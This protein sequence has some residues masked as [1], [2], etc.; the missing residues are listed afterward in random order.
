[1]PE[2]MSFSNRRFDSSKPALVLNPKVSL[3]SA[4][5]AGLKES[6]DVSL[7][8]ILFQTALAPHITQPRVTCLSYIFFQK[9]VLVPPNNMLWQNEWKSL[10]RGHGT[11]VLVGESAARKP[12][13]R[14]ARS[15]C[16][17]SLGGFP[18]TLG[19]TST[20]TNMAP[21]HG[22]PPWKRRFPFWGSQ[23]FSGFHVSF[24][25]GDEF[26]WSAGMKD[27]MVGLRNWFPFA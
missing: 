14:Q 15:G 8:C 2:L 3:L 21:E 19:D 11:H 1:M 10:F 9:M 16:V 25:G 26:L 27:K 23:H 12:Q 20:K 24:L 13:A 22:G 17:S 6:M 18:D 5:P 7:T 4:H